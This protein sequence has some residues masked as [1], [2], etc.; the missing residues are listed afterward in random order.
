MYT[1]ICSTK[2]E[3]PIPN[4]NVIFTVYHSEFESFGS[5]SDPGDVFDGT[6]QYFFLGTLVIYEIKVRGRR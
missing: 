2:R 4:Q 5:I 3:F 1:N 6:A